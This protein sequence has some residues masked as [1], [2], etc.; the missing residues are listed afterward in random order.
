VACQAHEQFSR[1]SQSEPNVL[2]HKNSGGFKFRR[3]SQRAGVTSGG[4]VDFKICFCKN[5]VNFLC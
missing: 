1:F 4:I 3:F 2:F 5:I